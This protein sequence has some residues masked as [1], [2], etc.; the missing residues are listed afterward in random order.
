MRKDERLKNQHDFKDESIYAKYQSFFEDNKYSPHKVFNSWLL[1]QLKRR[2][3]TEDSKEQPNFEK[4]KLSLSLKSELEKRDQYYFDLINKSE[5]IPENYEDKIDDLPFT[6]SVQR[7]YNSLWTKDSQD[8]RSDHTIHGELDKQVAKDFAIFLAQEDSL[9]TFK[10]WKRIDT[11]IHGQWDFKRAWI[12]NISLSNI[13][14]EEKKLI[15]NPSSSL[16]EMADLIGFKHEKEEVSK[17]Y[18]RKIEKLKDKSDWGFIKELISGSDM[19]GFIGDLDLR[20]HLLFRLGLRSWLLW[21]DQLKLPILQDHAL[22]W[23]K[24]VEDFEEL[25]QLVIDEQN[26]FQTKREHLMLMV[27]HNYVELLEKIS[28][29][30]YSLSEGQWSYSDNKDDQRIIDNAKAQY[31]T[32]FEHDLQSSVRGVFKLIF[33]STPVSKSQYFVG[34]FEWINSLPKMTP[35]NGR[36]YNIYNACLNTINKEFQKILNEDVLHKKDILKATPL[37]KLNWQVFEKLTGIMDNDETDISI[38]EALFK[39]FTIYIDSKNFRWIEEYDNK[40]INEAGNFAYIISLFDDPIKTWE[41]LATNYIYKHE[42]WLPSRIDLKVR[43]RESFIL[44]TGVCLGYT[45]YSSK[46]KVRAM[47]VIKLLQDICIKQHRFDRLRN[48]EGYQSI[49]H[50]LAYTLANFDKSRANQFAKE[51]INKIDTEQ[52]FIKTIYTLTVELSAKSKKLNKTVQKSLLK[53]IDER[54][55]IIEDKYANAKLSNELESFTKMKDAI[56]DHN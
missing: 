2:I 3:E 23:I 52:I 51:V 20:S 8:I 33:N 47:A 31:N 29:N 24:K 12:E 15:T 46:D 42:G 6:H 13:K 39:L 38:R 5:F 41:T 17:H 19:L 45:F 11:I 28:Y 44:M 35:R 32:W 1:D 30:L 21:V 16:H 34:V 56:L 55:W 53:R 14:S 50:F 54:F 36:N 22:F 7:F 9:N 25:V 37:E 48:D 43:E 10:D 18:E 27:L 49:L 40:S 4:L 26:T